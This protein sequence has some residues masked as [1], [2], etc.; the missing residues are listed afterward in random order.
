MN[1]WTEIGKD[2]HS[3]KTAKGFY[4]VM[5]LAAQTWSVTLNGRVVGTAKTAD[6]G[7]LI[8]EANA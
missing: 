6:A 4:H 2:A 3:L 1:T 5:K 8:A 7:K